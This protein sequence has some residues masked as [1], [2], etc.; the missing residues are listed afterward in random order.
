MREGIPADWRSLG[1]AAIGDVALVMDA[2]GTPQVVVRGT[3]DAAYAKSTTASATATWTPLGGVL[4][5][6]PSAAAEDATSSSV[7]VR[8]SNDVVYRIQ[9]DG[10][11]GRWIRIS[12]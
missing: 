1:G 11:W 12:E 2:D 3:N 5:T 6:S 9:Y 4:A 10:R 8:G 7:W